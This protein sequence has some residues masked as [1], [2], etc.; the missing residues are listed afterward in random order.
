MC[1]RDRI[2]ATAEKTELGRCILGY[3]LKTRFAG[4]KEPIAFKVPLQLRP[5]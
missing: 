2:P 1:I 5:Q 3:A 4:R